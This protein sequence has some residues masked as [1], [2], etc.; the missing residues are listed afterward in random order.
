MK[1]FPES[2]QMYISRAKKQ[3]ASYET[4]DATTRWH[5]TLEIAIMQDYIINLNKQD[6]E[7]S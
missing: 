2:D 3:H 1:K 5:L 6:K 4:A 7:L